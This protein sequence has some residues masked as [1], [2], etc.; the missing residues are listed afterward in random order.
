M[1]GKLGAEIGILEKIQA[2]IRG[3]NAAVKRIFIGA[4]SKNQDNQY[5]IIKNAQ[6]K[7]SQ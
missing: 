6:G 2:P 1:F 4:I 7:E 3:M 5:R